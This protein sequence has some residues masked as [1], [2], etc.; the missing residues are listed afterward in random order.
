MG[1]NCILVFAQCK[2][3]DI[4]QVWR[5]ARCKSVRITAER[6]PGYG[7]VTDGGAALNGRAS[8]AIEITYQSPSLI[9]RMPCNT[10]LLAPNTRFLHI[11]HLFEEE[12]P[13]VGNIYGQV[14]RL[15]YAASSLVSH[16]L[17]TGA[18]GSRHYFHR[19]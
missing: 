18:K 15:M 3:F 11:C 9:S 12:G 6:L 14:A 13:E 2:R 8:I 17:V 19:A 7:F 10:L 16:Q 5:A 4:L 1:K